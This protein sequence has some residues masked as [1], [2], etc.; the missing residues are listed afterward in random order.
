MEGKSST[1]SMVIEG[2]KKIGYSAL[3]P[4]VPGF[5]VAGDTIKEIEKETAKTLPWYLDYLK[6]EGKEVKPQKRTDRQLALTI[7]S[8]HEEL[9][10]SSI[11][12]HNEY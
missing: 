12:I 5:F 7:A 1:F 6:Q 8:P 9:R 2:N 10:F 3:L 4:D 11:T